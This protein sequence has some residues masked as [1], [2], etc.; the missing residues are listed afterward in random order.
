MRPAARKALFLRTYS[1]DVWLFPTD[2]EEAPSTL[3]KVNISVVVK[4]RHIERGDTTV[5]ITTEIGSKHRVEVLYAALGCKVNSELAKSVGATCN[6]DGL[7]RV[8][9]HQPDIC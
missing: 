9:D 2:S 4:P 3:A 5:C 6:A 7:V 8:D 1:R